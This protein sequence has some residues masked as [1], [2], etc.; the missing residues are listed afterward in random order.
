VALPELFDRVYF[1][2]RLV[3]VT[4]ERNILRQLLPE[5]PSD[6]IGAT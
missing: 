6:S 3:A 1:V 5:L 4:G 2:R